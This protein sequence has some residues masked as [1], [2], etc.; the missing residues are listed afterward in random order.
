MKKEHI[1]NDV[2]DWDVDE[3]DEEANESHDTESDGSG[4]SDL[5]E[6]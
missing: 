6:L 5:L 1:H 4:K 2:V 3:F